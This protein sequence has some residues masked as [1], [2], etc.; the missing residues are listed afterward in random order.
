MCFIHTWNT[1]HEKK[2]N[3]N[4]KKNKNKKEQ[5]F[6]P[7]LI[8]YLITFALTSYKRYYVWCVSKEVVIDYSDFQYYCCMNLFKMIQLI[9]K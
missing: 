9:D 4:T 6:K 5:R 8:I 7:F 1:T 2:S 3:S